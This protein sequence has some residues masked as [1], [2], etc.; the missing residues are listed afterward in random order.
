MVLEMGGKMVAMIKK[1]KQKNWGC[2]VIRRHSYYLWNAVVLF[3]SIPELGTNI[4]Y[5]F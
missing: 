4:F 3:E 2:S 5:K 1:I